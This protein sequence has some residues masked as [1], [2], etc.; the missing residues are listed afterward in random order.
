MNKIP[1]H[2]IIFFY[3]ALIPVVSFLF[4]CVFYGDIEEIYVC[5]I[6]LMWA[7]YWWLLPVVVWFQI[8]S[9][10][11]YVDAYRQV[12]SYDCQKYNENK[13]P[14]IT[15]KFFYFSNIITF[16]YFILLAEF[17]EFG[18]SPVL[19]ILS[20]FIIFLQVSGIAV[21]TDNFKN[22]IFINIENDYMKKASVIYYYALLVPLVIFLIAWGVYLYYGDRDKIFESIIMIMDSLLVISGYIVIFLHISEI[23][24]YTHIRKKAP[25]YKENNTDDEYY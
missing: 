25:E 10:V 2:T 13:I 22:K 6:L 24:N 12:N 11:N 21:Y 9:I 14:L 20:P 8:A 5:V 23:V 3:L 15:V 7:G 16:F 18:I 4:L 17:L 1:L 19:I